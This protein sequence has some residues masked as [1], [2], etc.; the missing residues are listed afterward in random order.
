MHNLGRS[1]SKI[2]VLNVT[3]SRSDYSLM[4]ELFRQLNEDPQIDH[5]LL[6]TGML[7]ID[8]HSDVL[9]QIR[10][11]AFGQLHFAPTFLPGNSDGLAMQYALAEGIKKSADLIQELRPDIVMLQ[12]DRGEML[13]AAIAAAHANCKIVHLSGGDFSGSIDDSIRNAISKFA[14]LHLTTCSRSSEQLV[15]LGESPSRIVEVGEPGLDVVRATP[16]MS[17]EEIEEFF[18]LSP[19]EKYILACQ[20]PVTTEVNFASSQIEQTLAALRASG[21]KTIFTYP[22]NDH[23]SSAIIDALN[24]ARTETWIRVV[25]N[26]GSTKFLSA[27]KYASVLVGNSSSGIWE[28]PTLRVPVVNIGTRQ[29]RRERAGN[30]VDTG[31]DSREIQSAITYCLENADFREKLTHL[32]NPYGEGNSSQKVISAIKSIPQDSKFISKWLDH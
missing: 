4:R 27:L 14:H 6:V 8:N 30:V 32:K 29:Y 1:L 9:S 2:T 16:L 21:L 12:G 28:A 22:N 19:G 31:Y 18:A 20:H 13:A 25:Q 7:L 15:A 17:R 5:H 10:A 23:G 11:D 26:L 3:G 24:Q